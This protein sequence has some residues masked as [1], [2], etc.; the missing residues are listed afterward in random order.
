MILHL[1]FARRFLVTFLYV[2]GIFATI[3]FLIDMVEQLRRFDVATL[4][5][6]EIVRLTLLRLPQVIYLILPLVVML[7]TIWLF[8]SLSR[9]SELVVTRAA[10]RSALRS[11]VAPVIVAVAIGVAAVS[12][13][14]PVVAVTSQLY[15]DARA[16]HSEGGRS[17]LSVS[18][19]GLWLRQGSADG[20]VVIR[21]SRANLD[22]TR[23][24]DV[25]FLGTTPA[26]SPLFRLEA[27]EAVLEDG[28]WR[29]S[30]VKEWRFDSPNP[31]RDATRHVS[32]LLP[33]NLTRNQILDSFGTPSAV[34]IWD[35]PGF[36][37]QLEA[38]GF[39]A[40]QHRVWLQ[41]EL[42]QPLLLAS[43]VLIGA[44]FTMRH[45]RFGRTGIMVMASLM[46]GFFLYFL[47]NLAQILGETG[48]VPVL[49]AAWGPPLAAL[50]LPI[51]ILLHLED[52]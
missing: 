29:L 50:L 52:G 7:A 40:R 33:S 27:D 16:E 11:L 21:A 8:L 34:P 15:E 44:G 36:I 39:S 12:V 30:G 10:G 41:M 42:A 32:Y 43:M 2:L 45:V 47:R 51:G 23:L 31:E 13:M 49:L 25:T 5:F 20:Q 24:F 48:Q 3:S 4:G 6:F 28:A 17:T 38:A 9:S 26:G 22:G 35:L 14:N 1:Y 19:E 18:R 37:E 46:T